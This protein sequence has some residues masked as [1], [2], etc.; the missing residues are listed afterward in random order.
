MA[1]AG[2]LHRNNMDLIYSGGTVGMMDE[3]V[4]TLVLL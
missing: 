1:L 3:L 2:A 4:K